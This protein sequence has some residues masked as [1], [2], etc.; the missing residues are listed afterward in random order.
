MSVLHPSSPFLSS[1]RKE[2]LRHLLILLPDNDMIFYCQ[3]IYEYPLLMLCVIGKMKI[4]KLA[5][6]LIFLTELRS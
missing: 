5:C 1:E 4:F 2:F 3:V 6:V